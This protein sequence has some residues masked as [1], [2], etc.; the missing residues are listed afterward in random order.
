LS[1]GVSA[2]LNQEDSNILFVYGVGESLEAGPLAPTEPFAK[3]YKLML[4]DGSIKGVDVFYNEDTVCYTG[5]DN[6]VQLGID[7]YCFGFFNAKPIQMPWQYSR[8]YLLLAKVDTGF[9]IQNI[10][11]VGEDYFYMNYASCLTSDS[12]LVVAGTYFDYNSGEERYQLFLLKSDQNFSVGLNDQE[13]LWNNL[14]V[15]PN[16]ASNN[17]TLEIPDKITAGL[18]YIFNSEGSIVH[19]ALLQN[20][21]KNTEVSAL[22]SGN[23][24]ISFIAENGQT[25]SGQFVKE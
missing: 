12:N 23:Y 13:K 24:F 16:P 10:R 25:Y 15:Y 7:L 1:N 22:A 18:V 3:L 5:L 11:L 8:S 20:G 2:L 6:F 21:Q 9:Q 19:S 4:N 17:I 14:N